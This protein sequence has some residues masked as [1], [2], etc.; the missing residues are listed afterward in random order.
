MAV[1]PAESVIYC[2]RVDLKKKKGGV[3][4]ERKQGGRETDDVEGESDRNKGER[5]RGK[6]AEAGR[7]GQVRR[8]KEERERKAHKRLTM[9]PP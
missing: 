9:R 6:R 7:W 5:R 3:G 2:S 1:D 8:D 4:G